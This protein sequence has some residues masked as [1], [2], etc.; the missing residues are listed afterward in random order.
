MHRFLKEPL[1][2]FLLLGVGLF[3]V[4]SWLNPTASE[5]LKRINVTR[6]DLITFMQYRARAI[7]SDQV[8]EQ[9]DQ[10]SEDQLQ[11]LV[12]DY[13]REEAMFREAKALGL[14]SFDYSAKR[15]LVQ[16]LEYTLREISTEMALSEDDL[17]SFY[18]SH[19]VNYYKSPEITFTHVFV[20]SK[21]IDIARARREAKKT[22]QQLRQLQLPFH[23]A[24]A[25][26]DRFLY[27]INYVDK[28]AEEVA[29]HFGV[30]FQQQLFS[31]TE[32]T[33]NTWQGPFQS[34]H[35]FHLVKLARLK[36]GY[37]PELN[38]IRALLVADA[39]QAKLREVLDTKINDIVR[40]YSINLKKTQILPLPTANN[41][42]R[43]NPAAL[44][45]AS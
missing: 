17:Q 19:K 40:G 42:A 24:P 26:G 30:D 25:Y 23:S 6:V 34:Q 20:D 37:Q 38:E 14:D 43:T 36:Q 8:E 32:G 41:K 22:L 33:F 12:D 3:I 7:S 11:Q 13:V 18:Q 9:L 44:M 27:H 21:K 2:H 45:D 1:L 29:S 39:E 35:G 31:L 10:M 28:G 5:D 4:Y 15:R 16:R